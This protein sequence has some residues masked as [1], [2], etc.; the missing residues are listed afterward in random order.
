LELV[1]PAVVVVELPV[2]LGFGDWLLLPFW[3]GVVCQDLH[4]AHQ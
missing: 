3:A 2:V 4:K 1:L